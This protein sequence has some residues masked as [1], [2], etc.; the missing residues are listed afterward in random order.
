MKNLRFSWGGGLFKG[1]HCKK[2]FFLAS[3]RLRAGI[4]LATRLSLHRITHCQSFFPAFNKQWQLL[5]LELTPKYPTS[6]LEVCFLGRELFQQRFP[7]G[8][9]S[10]K[11]CLKRLHSGV[12]HASPPRQKLDPGLEH[13]YLCPA[14]ADVIPPS[15]RASLRADL[16][17]SSSFESPSHWFRAGSA[18]PRRMEKSDAPACVADAIG[19]LP[20]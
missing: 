14:F 10:L 3:K 9:I 12:A 15:V 18:F 11:H 20:A 13:S 17:F 4:N 5:N 6:G 16:P 19:S 1:L 2:A 7:G 8:G